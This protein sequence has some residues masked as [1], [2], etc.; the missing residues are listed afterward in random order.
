[1]NPETP[2]EVTEMQTVRLPISLIDRLD[3]A[4]ASSRRTKT[5]IV[6]EALSEHLNKHYPESAA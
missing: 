1:M 3:R 5:T 6:I 2:K 4:K